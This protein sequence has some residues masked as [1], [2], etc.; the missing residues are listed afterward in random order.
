MFFLT[1]AAVVVAAGSQGS[2]FNSKVRRDFR[3]E[4]ETV[5]ERLH[6]VNF[7][8]CQKKFKLIESDTQYY[9]SGA[10]D[11]TTQLQ[12]LQ[13]RSRWLIRVFEIGLA[14]DKKM[15]VKKRDT[16]RFFRENSHV[17]S[18]V[19]QVP[20]YLTRKDC[21]VNGEFLGRRRFV[22]WSNA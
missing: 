7:P 5:E 4:H 19:S 14:K 9:V 22:L 16:L 17:F 15:W 20:R 18:G 8:D 11:K 6:A 12:T 21:Q 13:E 1:L 10:E 2:S 3:L